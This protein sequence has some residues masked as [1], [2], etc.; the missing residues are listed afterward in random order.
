MRS[1]ELTE[2]LS[3]LYE[4]EQNNYLMT[5][6]IRTLDGK[7]NALGV[8]KKYAKPTRRKNKATFSIDPALT[9]GLCTI[10]GAL[11][12]GIIEVLIV[13]GGIIYKILSFLVAAVL[14]AAIGAVV[15]FVVFFVLA[16]IS[17][18]KAYKKEQFT[19]DAEY[20][21]DFALYK[22]RL[23]EDKV[24]VAK[25]LQL[26]LALS[27]Q[28]KNLYEKREESFR[29]LEKYYSLAGIDK[30]YR[31]IVPIGYM[32]EFAR[33]GISK[34]LEGAD[35]LYYLVRQ[36]LRMD[37]MQHTLDEISA[38]LDEIVNTQRAIYDEIREINQKCSVMMSATLDTLQ[39]CTRIEK[40]SQEIAQNT[41]LSAYIAE[42]TERELACY[43]FLLSVQ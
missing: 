33:L 22:R 1:E 31:N 8:G 3:I 36:E 5:R 13:D 32:Y 27:E 14:G 10:A 24:R 28:R 15:G 9:I 4:A 7:I 41:A 26:R 39:S 42:R 19:I 37:E 29:M 21:K 20:R 23:E 18:K 16:L 34:K 30:T 6:A 2:G 11:I 12:R 35:G 38:K 25:E 17:E 43:A 40:H